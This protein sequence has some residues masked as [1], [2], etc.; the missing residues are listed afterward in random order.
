MRT[1]VG[2]TMN[3]SEREYNVR[4]R[5]C[6]RAIYDCCPGNCDSHRNLIEFA[7]NIGKTAQDVDTDILAVQ[8]TFKEPRLNA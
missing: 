5:A 4:L 3:T 2:A 8:A 6:A 1:T 7:K